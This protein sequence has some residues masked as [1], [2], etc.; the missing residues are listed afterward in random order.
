MQL[1][2]YYTRFFLKIALLIALVLWCLLGQAYAQEPFPE[3]ALSSQQEISINMESYVFMPSEIKA[4]VGHSL[5]LTLHNQS[6]LVPHNFL[7]DDPHGTRVLEVDLSSG[8][9]QTHILT[10]TEPGV[11][12]FYCDKQLLFFPSHRE[13]GMEGRLIVQ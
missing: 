8:E 1:S 5:T 12:S 6:F 10:L 3:V 9:T 7:L 11:Y 2:F 13:E 4:N